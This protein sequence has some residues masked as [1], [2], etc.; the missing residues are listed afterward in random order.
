MGSGEAILGKKRVGQTG[1]QQPH[2]N[3]NHEK[4]AFE[5]QKTKK[6][7]VAQANLEGNVS[8]N[9]PKLPSQRER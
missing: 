2:E 4:S 5:R 8:H 7:F 1:K 3:T 9:A 6:E